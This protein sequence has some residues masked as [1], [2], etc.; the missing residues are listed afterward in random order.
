[1]CHLK[2]LH[3]YYKVSCKLAIDSPEFSHHDGINF[4]TLFCGN[5][6]YLALSQT[7][8]VCLLGKIEKEIV[9]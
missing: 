5:L 7:V 4:K 1:M 2:L 3:Y 9:R 8:L 6:C